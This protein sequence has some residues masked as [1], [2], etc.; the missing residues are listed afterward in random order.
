MAQG[1]KTNERPGTRASLR[2]ARFSAYKAR[3][4]LN[5]IRGLPVAEARD[6]LVLTERSAADHILKL[7]DSAVANAVANDGIGA[8]ELFVSACFADEGPT[9]KRFR[10]RARGRAGR[11]RKRTT[12]VTIIVSRL[13]STDLAA[14][15]ERDAAKGTARTPAASRAA[16]VAKSRQGSGAAA[17]DDATTDEAPTDDD[18][19]E[20]VDS[21]EAVDAEDEA[22][23]TEVAESAEPESDSGDSDED[24]EGDN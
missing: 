2:Y 18:T 13:S 15:R 1:V 7:L 4:V 12:H 3:E 24:P 11:I 10:P 9:L 16:R 19:D 22:P 14:K 17:A 21:T 8:D 5:L 6:I 23:D 20:V